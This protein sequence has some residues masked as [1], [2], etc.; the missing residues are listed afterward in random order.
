MQQDAQARNKLDIPDSYQI[1]MKDLYAFL[2]FIA[3]MG[4]DHKHSMKI[5][6]TKVNSTMFLSIPL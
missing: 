2:S 1:S 6:L 5:Y 4:H 3:R